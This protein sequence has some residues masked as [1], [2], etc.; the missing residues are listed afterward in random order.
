MR[1]QQLNHHSVDAPSP[2]DQR[3]SARQNG[4]IVRRRTSPTW[5][6][7]ATNAPVFHYEQHRAC[8]LALRTARAVHWID[9]RT[10]RLAGANWLQRQGDSNAGISVVDFN[11]LR[12]TME[13]ASRTPGAWE[14]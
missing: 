2:A 10:V 4:L 3:T 1:G 13:F 8:G 14:R 9:R 6:R 11:S 5:R 7:L 12:T